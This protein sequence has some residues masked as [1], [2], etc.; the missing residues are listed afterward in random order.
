MNI[1]VIGLFGREAFASHIYQ[2]L[3]RMNHNVSKFETSHSMKLKIGA[4][5]S[6]A[7]NA[8]IDLYSLTSYYE[9]SKGKKLVKAVQRFDPDLIISTYDYLT[10]QN[11]QDLK[12]ATKARIC[13]W[14]PDHLANFY[15]AHFMNS[16]YD[17][18]FFKDPFIVKSL[19]PILQSEVFYLPECFNPI[20]LTI[21]NSKNTA[22]YQCDITTAGNLHSYRVAFFRNLLNQNLDIKIWGFPPPSW[23]NATD[24][25]P[26]FQY[27]PVYDSE[28]AL[29]FSSAKIVLNNLHYAEI[30]GLNVRAFEAAGSR[31][32]QL[33]DFRPA[34]KDLFEDGKEIVS[35]SSINDLKD[36]I[37][38]YLKNP[39]LRNQIA[40]A[41]FDRA[42][43]NH[44]Y[45]HRLQL[46]I[47][48]VFKDYQGYK[49]N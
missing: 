48:T 4:P 43:K 2:T 8:I 42:I 39:A 37:N 31:A 9:K 29:A 20:S 22:P 35:F 38:F 12:K 41:G 24:V 28:K 5:A 49:I 27:K 6:K 21:N 13:L 11:I 46:L 10:F 18:I 47:D 7:M 36:K 45:Q 1:L 16:G 3:K 17:F 19:K 15:K 33:I 30:D 14:F 34:L 44:T 23:L 32:F 40:S 25:L 26:Y